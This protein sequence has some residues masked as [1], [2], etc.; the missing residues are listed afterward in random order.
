LEESHLETRFGYAVVVVGWWCCLCATA[1]EA[2]VV[3]AG[4]EVQRAHG[5]W[6]PLV[7]AHGAVVTPA[8]AVRRYRSHSG[9][10]ISESLAEECEA[11]G[12]ARPPRRVVRIGVFHRR[13]DGS[14]LLKIDWDW[15]IDDRVCG[16][17]AICPWW[18]SFE[19]PLWFAAGRVGAAQCWR[20]RRS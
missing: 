7:V 11:V 12:E 18:R 9:F 15:G 2:R 8:M 3:R 16:L 20:R 17:R 1:E 5:C 13:C 4:R 19:L 10:Q 6:R 14:V